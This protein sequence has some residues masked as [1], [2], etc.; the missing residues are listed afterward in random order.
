MFFACLKIKL[1]RAGENIKNNPTGWLEAQ[2]KCVVVCCGCCYWVV[3]CDVLLWG[4]DFGIG[5]V[6]VGSTEL[7]SC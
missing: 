3:Q 5:W 1:S 6:P 7:L 4:R 2:G